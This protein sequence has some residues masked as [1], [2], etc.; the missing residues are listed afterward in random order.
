MKMKHTVE[1][2]SDDLKEL[3]I[4]KLKLSIRPSEM[5]IFGKVNEYDDNNPLRSITVEWEDGASS[6]DQWSR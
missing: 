1:I 6:V 2:Q 5:K 3:V 4:E